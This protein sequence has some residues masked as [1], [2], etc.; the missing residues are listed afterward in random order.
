[1]VPPGKP[2]GSVIVVGPGN[3]PPVGNVT[4]VVLA[5]PQPTWINEVRRAVVDVTVEVHVAGG[6]ADG[7]LGEESSCLRVV[8]TG[9]VIVVAG[10]GIELAASVGKATDRPGVIVPLAILD[11]ADRAERG[12]GQLLNQARLSAVV[13]ENTRHRSL[14]IS[15]IE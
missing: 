10:L 1:M 2:P 9:P 7:V 3:C 15:I 5:G 8:V 13:T 12:V 6:E 11:A 4:I 14:M